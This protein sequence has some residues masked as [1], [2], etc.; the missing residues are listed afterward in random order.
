L[1]NSYRVNIR[2]VLYLLLGYAFITPYYFAQLSQLS[3]INKTLMSLTI[4]FVFIYYMSNFANSKLSRSILFLFLFYLS[5]IFSNY[6]NNSLELEE[7]I[8]MALAFS[9]FLFLNY[10][11]D[12]RKNLLTFLFALKI[13]TFFYI[14]VNLILIYIYPEGLPSLT[15]SEGRKFYLFGNTN[16]TTRYLIPCL[17]FSFLYDQLK[18][19]KIG[20]ANWLLLLLSWLTLIK[21]W[22]VTGMI[23]LFIF[24]IILVWKSNKYQLFLI[25]IGMLIVSIISSLFLIIFKLESN[26]LADILGL[27]NKDMTFSYRDVLWMN[28]VDMIKQSP[29]WG[30]GSFTQE[31][32][33]MYIGNK[34]SAHNYY[35]DVLLR[36]GMIALSFLILGL[37]YVSKFIIK[38]LGTNVPRLIIATCASY[39]IMW[40]AEPFI[41]TENI[42]LP[43]ILL[44]VSRLQTLEMY[45]LDIYKEKLELD[46]N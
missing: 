37:L 12:N 32:M 40:I 10:C 42:M 21:V 35:L 28:A 41:S 27:F 16:T 20:K 14:I 31:Q 26:I 24:T 9:F 11:L 45:Q 44:L 30:Y 34:F 5:L 38:S 29:L 18:S 33:E 36:G 15:V 4:V 23:G 39:F 19:G 46:E 7:F 13:L 25:Y 8:P 22:A 1:L 2:F 43:I 17:M 6:R 3:I